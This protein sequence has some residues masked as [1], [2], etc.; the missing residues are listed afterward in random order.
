MKIL[1]FSWNNRGEF[2]FSVPL[3]SLLFL[4]LGLPAL[5]SV[6]QKVLALENVDRFKRVVYVPGD[7][8]RF[9]MEDSKTVYVGR[10]ES[11]ND[12]QMVI[13]KSLVMENDRDASNRVFREYVELDKIRSVYKRPKGTYGEFFY[14][15]LSGGLISGGLM[16]VVLL[17]IDALLG[18][19]RLSPT[20]MT[21]GA[22]M[23]ATG[24]LLAIL[25]K[26]KHKVGGKWVLKPMTPIT[27]QY[28]PQKE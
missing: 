1:S 19:S 11:V 28:P 13:L 20:N 14:G 2:R 23:L 18:Q 22:S 8:I 12:S 25:R 5:Q 24:G 9:Q 21:I 10:I 27:P 6:G 7:I 4:L 26:K 17:P 3:F 15:M 16:Y